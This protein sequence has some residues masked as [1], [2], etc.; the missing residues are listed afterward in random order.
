MHSRGQITCQE[1]GRS[2]SLL[3][4]SIFGCGAGQLITL[5]NGDVQDK[6]GRP[7]DDGHHGVIDPEC[8][9]IALL[10]YDA[11]MKV[12][13]AEAASAMQ[14]L[15]NTPLQP[16]ERMHATLSS[17]SC[18]LCT[19]QAS[20]TLQ[21]LCVISP[22]RLLEAQCHA[23]DFSVPAPPLVCPLSTCSKAISA[24]REVVGRAPAPGRG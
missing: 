22:M 14:L 7:C 10:M 2:A 23:R 15:N 9:M 8:R 3:D 13:S 5:A 1:S 16:A 20:S 17:D 11:M 21:V 19:I 18:E 4:S 6:V 12:L 24:R